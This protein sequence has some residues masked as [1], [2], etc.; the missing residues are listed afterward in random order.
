M[1]LTFNV[2]DIHMEII[3]SSL[4]F[5]VLLSSSGHNRKTMACEWKEVLRFVEAHLWYNLL[6]VYYKIGP[7]TNMISS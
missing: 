7:S 6:Q 1:H 3:D 2:Y 4:E 5:F